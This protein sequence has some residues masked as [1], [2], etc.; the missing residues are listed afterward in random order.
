MTRS[1]DQKN[2]KAINMIRII[3]VMFIVAMILLSVL[4]FYILKRTV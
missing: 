1:L 4:F 3:D 2:N